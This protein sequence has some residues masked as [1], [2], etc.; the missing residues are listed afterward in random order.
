MLQR[1]QIHINGIV[2]GVGFR[3]FVFDLAQ[4]LHLKGWVCNTSA[5]VDI[6]VDGAAP[7]LDAF[8]QALQ[9]EAPP[10]AHIDSVDFK[11]K[12]PLGFT[13]FEIVP[14][15]SQSGDFQPISADVSIC[16]DC[17]AELFD[18][19][20][21]H[22]RYPFVNC[23]N[24]GPRYTI[25]QDIPYDRPLTTM[26]GFEMCSECETEYHDPADRRF[27]A[28]PVSCPQCGPQVFLKVGDAIIV[29]QEEALQRTK[30]LIAAGKIVAIKGLGGFHLACDA[31]NADAIELLRQR[32]ARPHKPLAV[33]MPDVE[34]VRQHC[35]VSDAE[36]DLLT[37]PQRPIVL[38]ECM[39]DSNISPLVAPKQNCLGVMLPYTPLHYLLLEPESETAPVWVM[40]SGNL[41]GQ[42]IIKD[43]AE[44]QEQLS[45]I[46]DAFFLHDRPIQSRSDDAVFATS[47]QNKTVPLRRARGY[48]PMPV[49][50]AW[51]SPIIFAAGTELKNTFCLTRQQYAFLSPH[52]GDL[53]N[54]ET[55]QVYEETLGHY[56][57]LFRL[58]PEAIAY[59]L[60]P[61][62]LATRFAL[63]LAE[64]EKLPAVAV[65]HHHAHIAACMAEHKL[66]PAQPVIGIAFDGTGF[67]TD[68]RIW[69]GEVLVA[70]YAQFERAYHLGYFPMPGGDQAV[71]QPW[72]LA[73]ALLEM[74]DADWSADLPSVRAA[75]AIKIDLLQQQLQHDLNC[76]KTSSIGR[77]FDAVA[78]LIGIRQS[79][80]YEAQAAIELEQ[81]V[82][83]QEKGAYPFRI[84]HDQFHADT[85][86][87]AVV[88][89]WHAGVPM[90]RI[91]ARFHNGLTELVVSLCS[92]IRGREKIND[93]VLSGGVWQNMTLLSN[94]YSK[95]DCAGFTVYTHQKVPANDG[96]VALGQAAVAHH[97]L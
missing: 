66:P 94:T 93:V 74:I 20:D 92:E 71:R 75:D 78:A 69:G 2:Q 25:I 51:D 14:S 3:P 73:L 48:A 18:P 36:L 37:S 16:P 47:P 83:P 96:G 97:I 29:E 27:H 38:L 79:I 77:L 88:Q 57:H 67:G 53:K 50:M 91:A 80:S 28:Q 58:Q 40:T 95:L 82:D 7:D 89:D 19:R 8:V 55:M 43:D 49:H 5:G 26:R 81:C 13:G 52:I 85:L 70:D 72:R 62:Y 87:N 64:Q 32:K 68:G 11:T 44:A 56:Q 1:A 6:E 59:D 30:D 35:V 41:G 86:I 12:D 65:Q 17:L 34:T 4:R 45:G 15:Q 46:A 54:Y 31:T 23:T 42:P 84:E 39:P 63:T 10:L 9:S 33:M 24:C 21:R 60:H 22:C 61:D 90:E 76:P